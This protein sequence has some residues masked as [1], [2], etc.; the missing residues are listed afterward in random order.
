MSTATPNPPS[1]DGSAAR[2]PNDPVAPHAGGSVWLKRGLW[3]AW[4]A[5]PVA[6]LT[7]HL[8]AG[9]PLSDR[10]RAGSLTREGQSLLSKGEPLD[11]ADAFAK[12]RALLP[13]EARA[14]RLKLE[15]AEAR[16]RVEGAE[17]VEAQGMFERMLEEHQGHLKA[18]QV[19]GRAAS[20]DDQALET[21]LRSEIGRT[22][23]Y[24]AWLMRR[25]GAA[26]EEWK[27]ETEKARQHYRLLAERFGAG[28][29]AR[30]NGTDRSTGGTG[31]D[32]EKAKTFRENLEAVIRL[33]QMDLNDLMAK[34]LPKGCP[35][36]NNTCQ[37][38]REQR[39]SKSAPKPKDDARKE[40]QKQGAEAAKRGEGS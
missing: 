3:C 17:I 12:A 10:D 19:A 30:G 16:A 29:G 11:A 13:E 33:E 32:A 9:A 34:P 28:D 6:A 8:A 40:I 24:V 23:Y 7:F 22:T 5:I 2:S 37:K 1:P 26:P 31:P 36:C 14:E 20:A 39:Q 27:P 35:N 15:I 18:Q 4:A 25:Q 21:T 38:K